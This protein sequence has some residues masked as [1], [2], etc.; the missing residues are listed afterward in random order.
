MGCKESNQTKLTGKQFYCRTNF[1]NILHRREK[2]TDFTL[3]SFRFW[4][5][6]QFHQWS[7]SDILQ[8]CI[9]NWRS[10]LSKMILSTAY[11]I[12]QHSTD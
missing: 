2:L 12:P 8:N 7:V 5:L 6:V 9:H 3:Q 4:N 10:R 1:L 11:L